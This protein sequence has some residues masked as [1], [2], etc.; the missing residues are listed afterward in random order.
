MGLFKGSNF[1]AFVICRS[2]VRIATMHMA[3]E[4]SFSNFEN[5]LSIIKH[6]QIHYIIFDLEYY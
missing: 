3:T 5:I 2:K 4:S 6:N 1:I